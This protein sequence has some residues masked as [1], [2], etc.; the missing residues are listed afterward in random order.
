MRGIV[1]VGSRQSAYPPNLR[2]RHLAGA[3]KRQI[4]LLIDETEPS[5]TGGGRVG[6]SDGGSKSASRG[7]HTPPGKDQDRHGE[8]GDP[9]NQIID[10]QE[11]RKVSIQIGSTS[12]TSCDIFMGKLSN[13]TLGARYNVPLDSQIHSFEVVGPE[14]ALALKGGAPNSV[15]QVQLWVYL[16][17]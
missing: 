3:S 9:Q 17:S 4:C 8:G 6:Y 7:R 12:A 5:D 2:R 1:S 16:R 14:M 15:E 11:F 13:T 10:V